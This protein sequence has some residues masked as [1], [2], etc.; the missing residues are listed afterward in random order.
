[1]SKLLEIEINKN[2]SNGSF[3]NKQFKPTYEKCCLSLSSNKSYSN[4][5]KLSSIISWLDKKF[6]C[7]L[8]IEGS[9]LNR[10]NRYALNYKS[11]IEIDKKIKS[12]TDKINRR[13]TKVVEEF[14]LKSKVQLLNWNET[15][16][17][18]DFL[19][20]SKPLKEYYNINQN[21]QNNVI[22]TINIYYL[23]INKSTPNE[24]QI[25]FLIS[26]VLEEIAMLIYVY[27]K[28]FKIEVYPGSDQQ[29]LIKIA[30]G[31]F[32]NFPFDFSQRTHLSIYLKE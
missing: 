19:N 26:Y 12:E 16:S 1:M 17:S 28:G 31:L 22:E 15:I 25:P 10:W 29:I 23:K 8:I 6:K 9:Y 24:N 27:T 7:I 11:K 14:N 3:L 32:K 2:E 4:Y 13:I 21:F 30:K 18:I 20:V 5:K